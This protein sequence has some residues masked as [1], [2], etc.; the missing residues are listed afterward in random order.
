MAYDYDVA[1]S[2]L[3]KD[4]P[5]AL[6]IRERLAP[7]RVF[8]YP[9]AQE[10]VAGQEGVAAFRDVFRHRSL[11]AVVLFRARW[12]QTP[13]TQVEEIAIRDR[14]LEAGW[15]HLVFVKFDKAEK[16]PPWVPDSYI[17]LDLQ[18]FDV[19]ELIGVVKAKCAKLG[20]DVHPPTAA[21]RARRI[22]AAEKL[23]SETE[24]LLRLSAQPLYD[25]AAPLFAA[26]EGRL[27]KIQDR[28]GWT[29]LRDTGL[30]DG[31]PALVAFIEP[32]SIQLL[33]RW[34]PQNAQG[35]P[36]GVVALDL[37]RGRIPTPPERAKGY[38]SMFEPRSLGRDRLELKRVVEY[39][40]CWKRRGQTLST[41]AAAELIA[42][43]LVAAREREGKRSRT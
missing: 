10:D 31:R 18:A 28:T 30:L 27:A 25:A 42:E 16:S 40:W 13:W 29:I 8:V 19:A 17:Y 26:V 15:N 12:G 36:E 2:F 21:D 32:I 5:L 11:V 43:E 4:E 1:I 24:Q 34:I 39:G 23:Q 38:G 35:V 20:V 3:S 41:E 14:C 37:F 6:D 22:A 7:L 33:A 9:K